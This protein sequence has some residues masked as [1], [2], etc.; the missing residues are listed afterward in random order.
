MPQGRLRIGTSGYQYDHW[1]GLLYPGGLPKARWFERYAERFDTVE[2]NSTFYS[3]PSAGTMRGWRRRAPAGFLYALKLSRYLTHLKR[4]AEPKPAL[5][6]FAARARLLG[7]RLGPV[8]AQ[9]PP[10]FRR[11]LPRLEGFLSALDRR[12]RWALEFRDESW[13]VDPVYARL[14][15]KG[16]ALC[17]H[18]KLPAHP[19][20]LTA[21]FAYLRFHGR[22]YSGRYSR[23]R[24]SAEARRIRGLLARG[25]DVYV[26]FNND[27]GGHAVSD[28]LALG[29]YVLGRKP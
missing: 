18:D 8:L 23:Q 21:D 7:D 25:L 27:L 20:E 12:W 22:D 24:L 6:R 1:R 2:I 15:A 19:R 26:Y 9:L 4:L 13:L 28:A 29:R 14:R 11:D 16:V 3:L 10:G 17:I 5:R